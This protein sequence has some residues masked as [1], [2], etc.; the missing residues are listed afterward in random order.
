MHADFL[1]RRTRTPDYLI[2]IE[3]VT[4]A[5]PR[6]VRVTVPRHTATPSSRT[7]QSCQEVSQR[8][9]AHEQIS[10]TESK[11]G[12]RGFASAEDVH[13]DVLK[14]HTCTSAPVN[15]P[16]LSGRQ[17]SA[18]RPRRRPY[19]RAGRRKCTQRIPQP[20]GAVD[21]R[22]ATIRRTLSLQSGASIVALP[23]FSEYYSAE[24]MYKAAN[25]ELARQGPL[26][27]V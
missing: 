24:T 1:K 15:N 19:R 5:R 20:R 9:R 2:T 4:F 27:S 3:A 16:Q 23:T 13:A 17:R 12:R 26:A 21:G 7:R 18:K 8:A 11:F 6:R 25:T 14:R 10:A 22:P